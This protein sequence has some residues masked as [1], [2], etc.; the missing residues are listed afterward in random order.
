MCNMLDLRNLQCVRIT[1]QNINVYVP[2][3]QLSLHC[4]VWQKQELFGAQMNQMRVIVCEFSWFRLGPVPSLDVSVSLLFLYS[5]ENY[6]RHPHHHHQQWHVC[7][8]SY[9]SLGKCFPT[10]L[11]NVQSQPCQLISFIDIKSSLFFELTLNQMIHYIIYIQVD[12][13]PFFQQNPQYFIQFASCHW[14]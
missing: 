6:P 10:F 4:H 1:N 14:C 3:Y 5:T 7:N 2:Q 8:Y 11:S 9:C 12:I 13:V